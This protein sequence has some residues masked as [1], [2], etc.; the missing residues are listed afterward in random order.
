MAIQSKQSSG[1]FRKLLEHLEQPGEFL[2]SMFEVVKPGFRL[3]ISMP[4]N[5]PAP[6]HIYL[7]RQAEEVVDLI[8][9]AGFQIQKMI[10]IPATN[11]TLERAIKK[12]LT[13]SVGVVAVKQ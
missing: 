5:S 9:G 7:A 4:V 12:N 10:S 8:S 11:N 1:N 6:D 2:A 13:I 3:F